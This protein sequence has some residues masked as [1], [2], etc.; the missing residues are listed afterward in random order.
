MRVAQIDSFA[1]EIDA[2]RIGQHTCLIVPFPPEFYPDF[3][4]SS[5]LSCSRRSKGAPRVVAQK[6]ASKISLYILATGRSCTVWSFMHRFDWWSST[7]HCIRTPAS[8]WRTCRLSSPLRVPVC[9]PKGHVAG[10]PE[11]RFG[12]RQVITESR[13]FPLLLRTSPS[14][15]NCSQ[16]RRHLPMFQAMI[17][18]E[19]SK[20]RCMQFCPDLRG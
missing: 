13:S 17:R 19:F 3:R 4:I 6:C 18:H 12:R 20:L 2:A 1:S 7:M 11:H 16:Q 14:G 15:W 9:R 8:R 5:R 10:R